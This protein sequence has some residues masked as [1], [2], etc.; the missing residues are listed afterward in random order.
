VLGA[1]AMGNPVQFAAADGKGF[2]LIADSVL[3]LN[4]FNPLMAARL[5]ASFEMWRRYEPKRQKAAVK[6]LERVAG[7]KK[8]SRDVYEIASKMLQ[9]TEN[10][11]AA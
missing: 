5:L 1:F 8:L 2:R 11:D 4:G 6:Q 10:S 3:E 9:T 7:T